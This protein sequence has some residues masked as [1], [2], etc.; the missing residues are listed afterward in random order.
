MK[1]IIAGGGM[2]GLTVAGLLARTGSHEVTVLEHAASFGEAGYGIGLYPLGGAVFNALGKADELAR[3]SVV[4]SRY[5]VY[6][7]H[8]DELQSVD[9]GDLLSAYG[10]MLGVSRADLIDILSSCVPDGA[11]RFGVHAMSAERSG[12]SV[13]VHAAD[14]NSYE[15]DVAIAADGMN[16]AIRTSLFGEVKRHDTGFDAWMWWAP[17]GA[18]ADGTAAE[19]WGPSSFVGLYPMAQGTNVAV[20][21]PKAMSPDPAMPPAEIIASLRAIVAEHNPGVAG[22]TGLWELGDSRPFL[23][24]MQDVRAPQLT[25]L[26]DRLALVGDSGVGF[27]PTAGVGAS[28]ALRSAAALAYD[29]SLADAASAPLAVRRWRDRVS[30]LVEKNQ[31][32]SRQLAKVMMVKHGST[33]RVVNAV[34]RHMPVTMMTRSIVKS[35]DVP[36]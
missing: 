33:S 10:P 24:P 35:M 30:K 12:D 32:D 20:G 23:W 8:G 31:E 2:A 13:V 9:L 28:N 14:G 25:A 6:G 11:I 1:V 3:R 22:V 18:V 17:A 7:P 36:F 16:S 29:L 15:G 27:L 19:H 5:V 34:M 4:L 26:D 21:V